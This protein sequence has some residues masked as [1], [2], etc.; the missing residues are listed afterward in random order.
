[1]E[2][3]PSPVTTDVTMSGDHCQPVVTTPMTADALADTVVHNDDA[4]KPY[5]DHQANNCCS[6]NADCIYDCHFTIS[7][8]MFFQGADFLPVL[9]NTVVF[10]N[11]SNTLLLRELSPLS[12]PPLTLYS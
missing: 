2:V 9:L 12:K 6:D 7:L 5:N 1:M 11:I 8:S 10:D 3:M 4:N